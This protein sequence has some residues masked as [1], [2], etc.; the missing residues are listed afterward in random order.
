MKNPLRFLP[1]VSIS[2][3]LLT[4]CAKKDG[5]TAPDPPADSDTGEEQP[6]DESLT[7]TYPLEKPEPGDPL[8]VEL[9]GGAQMEF[10][11]IESGTFLMGTGV[12]A[13][14]VRMR[15]PPPGENSRPVALIL[16]PP[17]GAI[18]KIGALPSFVGIGFD[19]EDG[20]LSGASL[21]W[22]SNIDGVLGTGENWTTDHLSI[23]THAITLQAV[24]SQRVSRE[25]E[26]SVTVDH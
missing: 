16:N 12:G 20:E 23:G 14:L 13:R 6:P 25:T 21:I 15:Q 24:D 11:W 5:P 18:L 19:P 7:L 1:L 9:P 4:G 2:I 8:T 26:I 22:H 10:V 3:L 17:T